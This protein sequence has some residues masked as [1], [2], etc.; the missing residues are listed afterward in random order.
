MESYI[1]PPGLYTIPEGQI[2]RKDGSSMVIPTKI[3]FDDVI[4]AGQD[5]KGQGGLGVFAGPVALG[6]KGEI[7]DYTENAS[8]VQ[9]HIV[10]QLPKQN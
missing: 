3:D 1:N 7:R 4:T 2:H 9:F 6:A 10:A 5:D 8:R